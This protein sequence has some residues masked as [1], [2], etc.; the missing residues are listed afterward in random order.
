MKSKVF[1]IYG[2]Q[3]FEIEEKT[4]EII[5]RFPKESIEKHQYSSKE[6]YSAEDFSKE[7][8][9]EQIRNTCETVSFFSSTIVLVIRD[10]EQ[11]KTNNIIIGRILR[12]FEEIKILECRFNEQT[13]FYLEGQQKNH[14]VSQT[15]SLAMFIEEIDLLDSNKIEIQIKKRFKNK[16]INFSSLNSNTQASIE[17]YISSKI[18]QNVIY[19][20]SKITNLKTSRKSNENPIN[21]LKEYI[22]DLPDNLILIL[23]ANI[24]KP[25]EITSGIGMLLEKEAQ[26][27]K[28]TITYDDFKPVQWVV[29]KADS[30]GLVFNRDAAEILIELMGNDLLSLD[31]EIEKLSI[32]KP[33]SHITPE[34]LLYTISHNQNF[35]VFRI[36][37]SLAKKDLKGALESLDVISSGKPKELAGIFGLISNQFRNL[38]KIGYLIH[39]GF[40]ESKIYI[41]LKLNSW[42][43][44]EQIKLVK[45]FLIEEL[46]NILIY[47]GNQDL[48]LKYD[49]K[50][51]LTSLKNFFFKVCTGYFKNNKALAKSWVPT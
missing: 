34:I 21:L 37:Q 49:Q 11:L 25:S 28:L 45:T 30:K 36:A 42:V 43:T 5:S 16:I 19:K 46:E 48:K 22:Q 20:D 40:P 32:L 29:Q 14:K 41:K 15:W 12:K 7:T 1:F 39:S 27:T 10:L 24:K 18:T 38:L 23:T 51:A 17:N 33:K 6:F 47:V 26:V 8:L 31:Q 4:K 50:E 44:K 13:L 35:S 3:Q 2:T 9:I